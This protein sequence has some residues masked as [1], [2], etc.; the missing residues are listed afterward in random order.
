M[1]LHF[2]FVLLSYILKVCR[3]PDMSSMTSIQTTG[4][5]IM[6]WKRFLEIIKPNIL[7]E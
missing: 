4:L 5:S 1:H 7:L 2:I 6:G 3:K